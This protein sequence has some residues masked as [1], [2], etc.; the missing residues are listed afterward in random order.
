MSEKAT[1]QP[2]AIPHGGGFFQHPNQV[3]LVFDFRRQ[4]SARKILEGAFAARMLDQ[5]VFDFEEVADFFEHD[6]R[7][8]FS[9]GI[10][11]VAEELIK[12]GR[13][14]GHVEVAGQHQTSRS[15]VTSSVQ[16]MAMVFGM[17]A[18]GAVAQVA[19]HHFAQER[20]DTVSLRAVEFGIGQVIDLIHPFRNHRQQLVQIAWSGTASAGEV[21]LATTMFESDHANSRAILAAVAL[22]L[23]EQGE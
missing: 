1:E 17:S 10:E 15:A 21:G 16:R 23:Q 3:N 11:A 4:R 22:L 12:Q 2:S 13:R 19:E 5:P 18:V 14:I 6:L 8:G 7:V 20:S 9:D